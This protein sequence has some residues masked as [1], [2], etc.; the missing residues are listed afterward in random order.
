VTVVVPQHLDEPIVEATDF[1]HGD[2]LLIVAQ[3]LAGEISEESVD[4]L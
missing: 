4:L 1:Q 3:T 2:V